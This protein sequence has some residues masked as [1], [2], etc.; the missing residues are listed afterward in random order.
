MKAAATASPYEKKSADGPSNEQ[1]DQALSE[2]TQLG[3]RSRSRFTPLD[4]ALPVTC[5]SAVAE[6]MEQKGAPKMFHMSERWLTSVAPHVSAAQKDAEPNQNQSNVRATWFGQGPACRTAGG[7]LR[8]LETHMNRDARAG[9]RG[10]A[11]R[12]RLATPA[13]CQ[14]RG[15]RRSCVGT[16]PDCLLARSNQRAIRLLSADSL[17]SRK[18][19]G[20]SHQ[21]TTTSC[22]MSTRRS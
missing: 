1:S 15:R 13:T 14:G 22:L 5:T 10:S 11:T 7:G 21:A 2:C 12:S 6:G 9:T 17:R 16:F 4:V 3:S 20:G 8:G 18:S 19:L